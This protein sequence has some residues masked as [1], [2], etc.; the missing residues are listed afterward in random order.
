MNV[1]TFSTAVLFLA[2]GCLAYA[3]TPLP[4]LI[5]EAEN[6]NADIKTAE[7]T[8]KAATHIARQ[9]T[10]LPD[11]QFTVQQFS[12]GSPRPFAGITNSDFAYIGFGA[13]QE[14]P[15]PGK[16][17]LKGQA[18]DRQ[19]DTEHARAR[20]LLAVIVG[21]VKTAYFRLAY[22]QQTLTFLERSGVTLKQ[23]GD[24]ELARYRTGQGSQADV[25]KAQLEHTKL[26]REITM[27]HAEMAE[28]QADLKRLL[29]RPQDSPDIVAENLTPRTLTYNIQDLLSFAR[30]RNPDVR[31]QTATLKKQEAELQSAERAGKPDFNIGYQFEETGSQYR[32]YY[33]LTFNVT[34]PRRRRVEAAIAE[35][36]ELR[37]RA[38]EDL[39]AQFQQQLADV[40]KQYVA[41]T[42]SVELMTEY[43]EGLIPQAE[44]AF[45]AAMT[46]YQSNAQQLGSV[47][48]AFND[49][50]NL[51]RDSAIALLDHE[52]AM[53]RLETLTGVTLQ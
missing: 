52:V 33:M 16:L 9:A 37:N 10:T 5:T 27:H 29:H 24:S 26:L 49:L 50:L 43:R 19:A 23:L 51:Q 41:A 28:L 40:Q 36:A 1:V 31:T 12:V 20:A 22:L 30:D 46:A 38:K 14:L 21:Q 7:L 35:A 47:L 4:A 34:V 17:R 11:P 8:W 45:R 15:Y 18:A 48:L 6:N 39:D 44:A 42:S 32:N 53:A 13:S 3:Q 25:L 2:A